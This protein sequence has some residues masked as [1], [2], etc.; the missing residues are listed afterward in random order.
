VYFRSGPDFIIHL[1]KIKLPDLVASVFRGPD[2][3]NEAVQLRQG[4]S[5]GAVALLYGLAQQI[6]L[7]PALGPGR[8]ASLALWQV[9]ARVI[10]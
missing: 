4:A 7:T 3:V 8:E 6:G 1:H 5:V 9:M 10:D 2:H